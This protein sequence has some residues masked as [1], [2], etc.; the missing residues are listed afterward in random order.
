MNTGQSMLSILA[1]LLLSIITLRV[2][3]SFLTTNDIMMESKFGILATSLAQSIIQEANNKAFDVNTA[4]GNTVTNA[5]LLTPSGNLNPESGERYPFFDDFDDFNNFDTLITDLPSAVYRLQCSVFYVSPAN[6]DSATN[7]QTWNKRIV[8][9]VTS[10]ISNDPT[11]LA[12]QDNIQL[13][14]VYSYWISN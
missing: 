8:V 12:S 1:I 5:V 4:N 6:L 11:K 2:N 7:N 13:S 9:T 10:L 14:S 3:K